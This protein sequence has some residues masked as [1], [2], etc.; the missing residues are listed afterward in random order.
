MTLQRRL[1]L[2]F[3]S[4]WLIFL[5]ATALSI[6]GLN[7]YGHTLENIFHDNYD[8]VVYCDNMIKALDE[9]NL[10]VESSVWSGTLP[11]DAFV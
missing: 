1:L 5:A 3:G 9:L 4:L 6:A 10:A 11:A 7:Y 2:G 8:S